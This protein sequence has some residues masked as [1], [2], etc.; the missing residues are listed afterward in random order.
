MD[1]SYVVLSKLGGRAGVT[2]NNN[3]NN[4]FPNNNNYYYY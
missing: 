4:Y 3:N 1:C 2:I